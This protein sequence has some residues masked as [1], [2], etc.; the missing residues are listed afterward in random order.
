VHRDPGSKDSGAQAARFAAVRLQQMAQ[1]AAQGSDFSSAY[2]ESFTAWQSL[3]EHL[4]DP[5]C[6]ILSAELLKDLEVYGDKLTEEAKEQGREPVN[7]KPF[8]FE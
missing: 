8:R 4:K 7:R 3:Q 5:E 1:S 6:K 2:S